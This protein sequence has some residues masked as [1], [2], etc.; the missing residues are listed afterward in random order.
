M[1]LIGYPRHELFDIY[2]T[3]ISAHFIWHILKFVRQKMEL[4]NSDPK[5]QDRLNHFVIG[6]IL[7]HLKRVYFYWHICPYTLIPGNK[8]LAPGFGCPLHVRRGLWN[9]TLSVIPVN[10]ALNG[11][12]LTLYVCGN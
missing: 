11:V 12:R 5:A 8:Y 4:R 2:S 6:E 3:Y 7:A 10:T 9:L 1:V